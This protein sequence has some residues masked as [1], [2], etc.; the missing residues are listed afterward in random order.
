MVAAR[1][2]LAVVCPPTKFCLR[3]RLMSAG[4]QHGGTSRA[5]SVCGVFLF[6]PSTITP[7]SH[8]K[9]AARLLLWVF[10]ANANS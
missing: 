8:L 7:W 9:N 3:G 5:G 10:Q 4:R 2:T 6:R 1:H